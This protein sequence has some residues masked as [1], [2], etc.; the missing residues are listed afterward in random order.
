MFAHFLC[1]WAE[2]WFVWSIKAH[3]IYLC[4]RAQFV[5]FIKIILIYF[6]FKFRLNVLNRSSNCL[7]IKFARAR[8]TTLANHSATNWKLKYVF[9]G[10][11]FGAHYSQASAEATASGN[12]ML[13]KHSETID[14][15][16]WVK[17]VVYV[18]FMCLCV[19]IHNVWGWCFNT[20]SFKMRKTR[21]SRGGETRAVLS[22][23]HLF[24]SIWIGS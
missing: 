23:F 16:V 13:S 12:R 22:V 24:C 3:F 8:K 1:K 17:Y 10:N 6:K 5:W 7:L 14:E 20:C 18:V 15:F 4:N 19:C 9:H 21:K 11:V 2:I